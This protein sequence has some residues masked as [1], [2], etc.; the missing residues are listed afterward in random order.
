MTKVKINYREP[1]DR[2]IESVEWIIY[3]TRS[4]YRMAASMAVGECV[5]VTKESL[6][7]GSPKTE[8]FI[9]SNAEEVLEAILKMVRQEKEEESDGQ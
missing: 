7:H 8:V 2:P 4:G 5:R 3:P 9:D 1:E 6:L